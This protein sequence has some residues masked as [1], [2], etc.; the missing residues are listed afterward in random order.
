MKLFALTT[1][2][3]GS[4]RMN[5]FVRD[6]FVCLFCPGVGDLEGL[7]ENELMAALTEAGEEQNGG[8]Q[9]GTE[10]GQ[11]EIQLAGIKTFVM[12]MEDGDYILAGNGEEVYWGDLGDYY[13]VEQADQLDDGSCHRRGVT[14]LKGMPYQE[15]PD[16]LKLLLDQG[17][18]IAKYGEEI[19]HSQMEF[20]L[21]PTPQS[22]DNEAAAADVDE[23]SIG[24]AL[25]ILKQAMRHGDAER[26]E[27][28]AAA[29]LNYAAAR[30]NQINR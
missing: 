28:A 13:Y 22:P 24:M 2:I 7:N 10:S 23:E 29:I 3:N 6:C 4:N 25:D 30:S 26:R 5:D 15:L 27:R 14:W 18:P 17:K 8:K 11:K 19:T 1:E 21:S 16:A 9:H 12:D 20:W